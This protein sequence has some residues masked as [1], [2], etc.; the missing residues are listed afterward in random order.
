MEFLGIVPAL[1]NLIIK[2]S[3]ITGI[4]LNNKEILN[5]DSLV[6]AIGHSARDTFKMLLSNNVDIT[7]K[8]FAVGIR[9]QHPQ[10]LINEAQYGKNKNLPNASYKLVYNTKSKRG[11]YSF[12]MC[13][14]GYVVNSSS[15]LGETVIN[16]MS[17][18][19]R[20]SINANS[21]IV[22]TVSE[23]DYGTGPLDGIRFQEKLE[24]LAYEL[25]DGKIPTQL[26]I[27]YKN[28]R[29]TKQFGSVK[30][31]FKGDYNFTNINDIFPNYINQAL[32]E[33]IEYFSKKIKDFNLDNAIISAVESRTSSPVRINRNEEFMSNIYGIYPCGEGSGYSGGIT[34]SA[35]DGVKVA[36]KIAQIY[37]N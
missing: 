30:P 17:N 28:N 21:A 9:I 36:E 27:D 19:K 24:S 3:K 37:M 35:I 29:N 14:G 18:Y 34:T 4:E 2:D 16:G 10:K 25:G 6:L 32:V 22:V 15:D 33:G 12:C 20:D 7:S 23:K 1:T 26:Y 13:P 5:C 31:V 8:P 11:V